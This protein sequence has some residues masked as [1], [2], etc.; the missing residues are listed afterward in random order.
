MRKEGEKRVTRIRVLLYPAFLGYPEYPDFCEPQWPQVSQR[1]MTLPGQKAITHLQL[2]GAGQRCHLLIGKHG[3]LAGS[4][5]THPRPL[6]CR[7]DEGGDLAKLTPDS[8]PHPSG[9]V[10]PVPPPT[11]RPSCPA[12]PRSPP[13]ASLDRLR[14]VPLGPGVPG[15]PRC[16]RGS[17]SSWPR[18]SQVRRGDS[19]GVRAGAGGQPWTREEP[20]P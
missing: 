11:T 2:R 3:V 8:F 13:T 12:P 14:R 5:E 15:A 7:E 4:L 1:V 9:P 18:S 16:S 19:R 6:K 10:L 17:G 20:E